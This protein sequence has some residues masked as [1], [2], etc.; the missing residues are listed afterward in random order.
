MHQPAPKLL[1][2]KLCHNLKI[3]NIWRN[4]HFKMKFWSNRM[5]RY[6][7]RR[8]ILRDKS[9]LEKFKKQWRTTLS[10]LF[11]VDAYAALVLMITKWWWVDGCC[12]SWCRSCCAVLS[13]LDKQM[14][15][16]RFVLDLCM[17]PCSDTMM[18][19][20]L[21]CLSRFRLIVWG[22]LRIRWTMFTFCSFITSIMYLMLRKPRFLSMWS[23]VNILAQCQPFK[24]TSFCRR[25]RYWIFQ[26]WE[27]WRS[28]HWCH[29]V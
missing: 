22:S 26:I 4:W 3:A 17:W 6:V 23:A 15:S 18:M 8:L 5:K 24:D 12:Y 1:N 16:S 27:F 25:W 7:I 13:R 21:L 10:R 29:N 20:L 2:L 28:R 14:R 19:M 9:G 11:L